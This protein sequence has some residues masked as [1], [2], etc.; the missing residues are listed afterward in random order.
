MPTVSTWPS[1]YTLPPMASWDDVA[2]AVPDLAARVRTLFETQKHM[3]LATLRRDGSPRISGTE[4]RF[5]DGELWLG[6][7][8]GSLKA[9][10]LQRDPRLAVHGPTVDAPP[11]DPSAWA[12]DAKIAGRAVEVTDPPEAD[13][14]HRF[15]IDITEVVHTRVGTPADHLAIESWHPGRGSQRLERR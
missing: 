2:E 1:G 11:D 13:G 5:E 4:V 12:G 14:S 8:A 3:T 15:R 6:M 9:R 7:M 10:D